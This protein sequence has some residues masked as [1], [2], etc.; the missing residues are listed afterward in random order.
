M[1]M[2]FLFSGVENCYESI[3]RCPIPNPSM[4]SLSIAIHNVLP[5]TPAQPNH[6]VP[7]LSAGLVHGVHSPLPLVCATE[8]I[9][10]MGRRNVDG[11]LIQ[12]IGV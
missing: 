3:L 12:K 5:T 2:R 6:D 11:V 10:D 4:A 9:G 7:H 8:D 1:L